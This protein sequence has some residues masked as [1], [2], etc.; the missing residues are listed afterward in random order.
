MNK[1]VNQL[2]KIF[3]KLDEWRHFPSYQLERRVDIFFLLYIEDILFKKLGI[4]IDGVVPEFPIRI[5]TID[6]EQKGNNHSKKIDYL[7]KSKDGDTIV[8]IE[9]K[10]DMKSRNDKQ[11]KF[12]RDAKEIGIER[13]LNGLDQIYKASKSKNKY[14]RLFEKLTEMKLIKWDKGKSKIMEGVKKSEI[15]I[16]YLQPEGKN[17]NEISFNDIAGVIEKKDDEFSKRFAKSVRKWS[18]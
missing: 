18:E 5:G 2:N 4:E 12:I 1:T 3:E 11:D 7:A 6:K 13:I 17:V 16:V 14:R 8:F 9:L 10:T 15:Q